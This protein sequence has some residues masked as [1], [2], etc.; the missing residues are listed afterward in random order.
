MYS[1]HEAGL[2]RSEVVKSLCH[3]SEAVGGAGCSGDDLIISCKSLVVYVVND[4][5][6][7]LTSRCRNHN[8][9][10]TSVDVCHGLLLRAV[11]TCALENYVDV[12]ILPWKVC[13]VL[14]LVDLDL[15][16]IYDDGVIGSLYSTVV[17]AV[18]CIILKKVCK[19]LRAGQIV[20]C[21]NIITLSLE[22]LSECETADTTET[23]NR[24]SY[25]HNNILLIF[26]EINGYI[27]ISISICYCMLSNVFLQV[28]NGDFV[29]N[30][31]AN[32]QFGT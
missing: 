6:Q 31:T 7:I 19:H 20:D 28:Q 8:V 4:G 14:L 24:N 21:Y 3:R 17:S 29:K 18:G 10:S 26:N 16:T 25:C 32:L 12:K 9:L 13:S 23:I 27:N 11:E 22:H 15:L 1:G 2:D 30:F 5:L